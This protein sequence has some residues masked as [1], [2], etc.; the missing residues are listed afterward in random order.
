MFRK[1][2]MRKLK[3]EMEYSVKSQQSRKLEIEIVTRFA[4]LRR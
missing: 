3:A 1:A 2:E 4:R